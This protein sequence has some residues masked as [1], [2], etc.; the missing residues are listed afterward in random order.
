MRLS[1]REYAGRGMAA[2]VWRCGACG[3]ASRDAPR[4]QRHPEPSHARRHAPV[5][6][7]SPPNPVIDAETAARLLRDGERS[8]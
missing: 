2:A 4:Q 1:H 6:E 3:T 8:P 7:G 5:D